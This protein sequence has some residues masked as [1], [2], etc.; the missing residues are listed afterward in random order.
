MLIAAVVW[1]I[2]GGPVVLLLGETPPLVVAAAIAG[3]VA[4]TGTVLTSIT[5]RA[6]RKAAALQAE[7]AERL[8]LINAGQDVLKDAVETLRAENL[9]QTVRI[10]EL[11]EIVSTG[12]T[13]QVNRIRE[14]EMTV[15]SM[16]AELAQALQ[17]SRDCEETLT[18][19]RDQFGGASGTV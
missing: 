4:L 5:S 1:L 9:R 17:H 15:N 7:N 10:A 14:L 18:A 12:N 6:N 2:A 11:E 3:T 16:R 19:L 8:G 13:R